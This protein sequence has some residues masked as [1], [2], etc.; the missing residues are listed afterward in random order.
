M[1][2]AIDGDVLDLAAA[3]AMALLLTWLLAGLRPEQRER[4]R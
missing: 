1:R 2:V 3:V 4:R